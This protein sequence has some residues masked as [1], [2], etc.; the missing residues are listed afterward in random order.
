MERLKSVLYRLQELY[1]NNRPKTA[2]DIDLM[3]DYTRVIYADLLEWRKGF[4]DETVRFIEVGK[5]EEQ[6]KETQP[7][8]LQASSDETAAE[9]PSEEGVNQQ[10]ETSAEPLEPMPS[11]QPLA[12]REEEYPT[13]NLQQDA[14]TEITSP[15]TAGMGAAEEIEEEHPLGEGEPEIAGAEIPEDAAVTESTEMA[16]TNASTGESDEADSVSVIAP[17]E[18]EVATLTEQR[19][20]ISFEPP[21]KIKL[22]NEIKEELLQELPQVNKPV[23][24]T[25]VPV[26]PMTEQPPATT[27]VEEQPVPAPVQEQPAPV[28]AEKVAIASSPRKDIRQSVGINDKYLFLNELFNNQKD[29][30][31]ETLDMLNHFDTVGD[32]IRWLESAVGVPHKWERNDSTVLSFYAMVQKHFSTR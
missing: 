24:I 19:T 12:E 11:E 32:A 10:A 16:A 30:Y 17:E 15:E 2:I 20:G 21:S 13:E 25:E 4:R 26:P 14:N 18:E 7:L 27:V 1:G 8:S 3:L 31:E 22:R 28:M 9:Q 6:K 29:S 23:D 5:S